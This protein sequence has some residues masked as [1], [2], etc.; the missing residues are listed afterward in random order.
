MRGRPKNKNRDDERTAKIIEYTVL[1]ITIAVSI[2]AA[3]VLHFQIRKMRTEIL[4]ERGLVQD[5]KGQ[6]QDKQHYGHH[7]V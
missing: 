6:L 2:A 5:E 7:Q 3:V 4:N 1:G